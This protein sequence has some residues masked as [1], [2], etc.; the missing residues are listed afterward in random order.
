MKKI[1]TFLF[2]LLLFVVKAQNYNP[3]VNYNFNGTPTNG[4]KIKTNI[5]YSNQSQMPNIIIE[6]YN[7]GDSTPINLSTDQTH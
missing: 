6:G 7:Y 1:S 4:I 2:L 3:I 5:P